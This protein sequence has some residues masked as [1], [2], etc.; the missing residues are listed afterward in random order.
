MGHDSA[1]RVVYRWGEDGLMGVADYQGRLCASL[2]LWNG[3]DPFLKERLFGL[4]GPE[5]SDSDI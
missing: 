5:V 4:S 2:A 3:K 1:Q